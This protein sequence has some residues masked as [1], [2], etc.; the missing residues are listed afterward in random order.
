MAERG[1]AEESL[2]ERDRPSHVCSQHGPSQPARHAGR[3][4]SSACPPPPGP[5]PASSALR[6]CKL[7]CLHLVKASLPWMD[8]IQCPPQ[9][10]GE[11]F[12]TI[13]C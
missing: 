11:L 6:S 13:C 2:T 12:N 7:A 9:G 1:P 8:K 4:L 10:P 3:G 5:C